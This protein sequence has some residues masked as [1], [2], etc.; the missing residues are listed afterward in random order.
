MDRIRPRGGKKLHKH[1]TKVLDL[2]K[3]Y[4]RLLESIIYTRK[5]K[6]EYSKR[7]KLI[8]QLKQ[9]SIRDYFHWGL[10]QK[11]KVQETTETGG[12]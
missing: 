10:H 8:K 6:D 1:V 9:Q 3:Q 12:V 2:A 7:P 11:S 5:P 4:L